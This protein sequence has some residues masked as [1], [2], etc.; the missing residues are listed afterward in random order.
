MADKT[1]LSMQEIDSFPDVR[2]CTEPGCEEPAKKSGRGY[3]KFCVEHLFVNKGGST[4]VAEHVPVKNERAATK[5]EDQIK[6]LLAATQLGMMAKGDLYCAWAV[7]E[8]AEGIAK[9]AGMVAADFKLVAR[10]VDKTDK[11]FAVT[12]L[13]Y[14]VARLGLMVGVHHGMIPYSGP[15]KLLV[16][17]P[18]DNPIE[19]EAREVTIDTIEPVS[20]T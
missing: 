14:N 19:A 4:P 11:Y 9:N 13:A 3:S 7:G 5:A 18:P 17:K 10:M 20:F 2:M 1:P 15:I 16:P 6:A 12:M 8:T